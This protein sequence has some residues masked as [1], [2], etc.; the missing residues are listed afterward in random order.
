MQALTN[1][2]ARQYPYDQ[3]V[4]AD[5]DSPYF[6]FSL[7]AEAFYII[8]LHPANSRLARQFPYAGMVFNAH[9]Q[10]EKLREA[11]H[12]VKMQQVVRMRDLV[13]SGSVNPMLSDFGN[14]SEAMQYTGKQYDKSWK[15][16]LNIPHERKSN[17]PSA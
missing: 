12:Y 11:N 17:H 10:F 13:Y 6:S 4:D 16:P 14:A 3:R 8:G 9:A 2:D 1:L 7:K 15:C 5:V